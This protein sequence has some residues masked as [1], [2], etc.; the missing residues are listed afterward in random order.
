MSLTVREHTLVSQF[1]LKGQTFPDLFQDRAL[2]NGANPMNASGFDGVVVSRLC[3]FPK[4]PSN[5]GIARFR[6]VW[7]GAES[8]IGKPP[9]RI[10]SRPQW[11]PVLLVSTSIS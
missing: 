3:T 9:L 1:D 8:Q 2:C 10:D 5:S 11:L 7:R 4:S 6:T